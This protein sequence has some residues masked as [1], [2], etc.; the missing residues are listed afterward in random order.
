MKYGALS[1]GKGRVH[2]KGTVEGSP[3]AILCLAW[4]ESGGPPVSPPQTSGFGSQMISVAVADSTVDLD[5]A[6]DGLRCRIQ[7]PVASLMW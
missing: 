4:T 3:D 7:I 6:A 5:Y 1:D 2:L